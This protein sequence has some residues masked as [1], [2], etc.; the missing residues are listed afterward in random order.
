M[1]IIIKT[2]FIFVGVYMKTISAESVSIIG[3]LTCPQC[4]KAREGGSE[5]VEC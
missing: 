4:L 1:I 3:E 5:W 2:F